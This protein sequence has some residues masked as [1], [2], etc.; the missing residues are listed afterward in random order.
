MRTDMLQFLPK[1]YSKVLEIGCSTGNFKEILPDTLLT[2]FWG[3]DPSEKSAEIAKVKMDK[4]LVGFYEQVENEIPNNYFDLIIANDVI[5]HMADQ[6][7]FLQSIKKKMTANASIV[8]SIPNVRFYNNLKKLLYDKD[9]QYED[10]GILDRTHLRFFTKK[11]IVRLLNENGFEIEKIKGINP[12]AGI[13][14]LNFIGLKI[15]QLMFGSDI[16]YFQFG[17]RAKVK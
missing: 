14:K 1:N 3:V 9:W 11:S 2:E 12:A 17:V 13:G 6:W 7:T 16:K 5:E 4:V 10:A 15:L 8:L